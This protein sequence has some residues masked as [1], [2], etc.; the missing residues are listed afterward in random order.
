MFTF[1]NGEVV[2]CRGALNAY[3]ISVNGKLLRF[4]DL[5]QTDCI[6]LRRRCSCLLDPLSLLG[7]GLGV[8]MVLIIWRSCLCCLI[9]VLIP[10]PLFSV[11]VPILHPDLHPLCFSFAFRF[12][13]S[14]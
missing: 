11:P 9:M 5:C 4:K 13:L 14:S 6:H 7:L 10:T 1:R 2:Q 12:A 3:Y 8:C